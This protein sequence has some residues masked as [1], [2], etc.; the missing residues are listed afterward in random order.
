MNPTG[1]GRNEEGDAQQ[2]RRPRT[3]LLA[4]Q[5]S[6]IKHKA[7]VAA[8][9]T[10]IIFARPK[11]SSTG[12]AL[13]SS[14]SGSG[15]GN[16]LVPSP[17]S[18]SSND[19]EDR[20]R[21]GDVTAT[22]P[23]QQ[24]PPFHEVGSRMKAAFGRLR[25]GNGKAEKLEAIRRTSRKKRNS[26][27]SIQISL[28]GLIDS[29]HSKV[30]QRENSNGS[31][32]GEYPMG[33]M[34]LRAAN[35]TSSDANASCAEE[36]SLSAKLLEV[37]GR[38]N[39]CDV[40]ITGKNNIVV[41]APSFL[42]ACQSAVFEEIFY[43]KEGS[44]ANYPIVSPSDPRKVRIEFADESTIKGAIH[45]CATLELLPELEHES[46]EADV[47]A[48]CQLHLFAKLFKVL[49][50]INAT[51]RAARRAMNKKPPLACAAFDE[52]NVL[53][54]KAESQ[55][56]WGLNMVSQKY[57]D[58]KAYALDFLRESAAET[59]MGLPPGVKFLSST[60]MGEII[61]DQEIGVDEYTM[62]SIL[63]L[64]VK[65][66][67]GTKEDK[68]AHAKAL[69]S[70]IQLLLIDPAQLKSQIKKCGFVEPDDV[71]KALEEIELMLENDSPDDK[72]RVIVEGAGDGR[73]NGVYVLAEDEVG[74]KGDEVMFL[75][76]ADEGEG[77]VGYCADF[78]LC[79]WGEKWGISSSAEYFNLLYYCELCLRKGHSK[80]KPPK[81]GWKCEGG[82]ENAPTCTWKPGKEERNA[83]ATK[84]GV[85]PSLSAHK[86]EK[87]G[88]ISMMNSNTHASCGHALQAS[89][90]LSQMISLP[91][92]KDYAESDSRY[93]SAPKDLDAMM[94]L[95]VDE[96]HD[97]EEAGYNV[98][99]LSAT[100]F[101]DSSTKSTKFGEF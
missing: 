85:A 47:R 93:A 65:R 22:Q 42:L 15:S 12:G 98:N 60:S 16:N 64:W 17:R 27:A 58:L 50:L 31:G 63:N 72:E 57:D 97:D 14:D 96:G 38:G 28:Q 30:E 9:T 74:L 87:G 51:Y 18:N 95:A 39:F 23:T 56:Y 80:R 6:D 77:G 44:K 70:H 68:I 52:C 13:A 75:K 25:R 62:W 54:E 94:H 40:E 82:P 79:L 66:G 89:M 20:Q 45:F 10:N 69:T 36:T 91:E 1:D 46:Y 29:E 100:K 49:P 7:A 24:P 55:N 8:S 33:Y 71:E 78:G 3:S 101:Y 67:P 83:D 86:N 43:P 41:R 19:D 26:E 73:V 99:Y 53:S 32:S 21:S 92:D 2:P 61:R 81:W 88:A 84:L 37:A 34:Q 35:L 90:T 76:E 59:M 48:L 11:R 5:L 4:M